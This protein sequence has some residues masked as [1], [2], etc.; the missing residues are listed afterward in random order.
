M[1]PSVCGGLI[2]FWAPHRDDEVEI[3]AKF[4]VPDPP[5]FARLV[6]VES[7]AGMRL[8]LVTVK[9]VNDRYMDTA[10]AAILRAGYACRIRTVGDARI[11]TLK[12]LTPPSDA[13]HRREEVE[14]RLTPVEVAG[15]VDRWPASEA[16]SLAQT[17]T[18]GQPLEVLFEIRQERFV[19]QAARH[20]QDQPVVEISVDRVWFDAI[21]PPIYELEAELLPEGTLADLENLSAELVGR[22][23]VQPQAVSKFQRGLARCR[24]A[25]ARE[26]DLG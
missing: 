22:W 14:V 19:R 26:F 4:I 6:A 1:T 24:P 10:D 12:S 25:L 16:A 20:G 23:A 21:D 2:G 9:P 7:L 3:E 13:L 8:G 17:L 11:V 18:A 15:P 5:T